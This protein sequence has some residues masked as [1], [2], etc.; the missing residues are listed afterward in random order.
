MVPFF[1]WIFACVL[2]RML[3]CMKTIVFYPTFIT[4]HIE[5]CTNDFLQH[6]QRAL[7]CFSNATM[8]NSMYMPINNKY[9]LIIQMKLVKC[10]YL[11]DAGNFLH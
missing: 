2:C 5:T 11:F 9:A 10:L 1:I 6:S 8:T 3:P 7:S 4:Y